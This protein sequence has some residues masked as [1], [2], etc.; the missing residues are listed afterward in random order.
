MIKWLRKIGVLALLPAFTVWTTE[1]D[2]VEHAK[3]IYSITAAVQAIPDDGYIAR[4]AFLARVNPLKA[5]LR[6]KRKATRRQ[7]RA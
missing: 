7:S 6:R 2:T 1:G 4:S 5:R 3:A